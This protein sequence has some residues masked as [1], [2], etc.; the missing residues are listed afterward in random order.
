MNDCVLFKKT[1]LSLSELLALISA[2][3]VSHEGGVLSLDG[4]VILHNIETKIKI[5]LT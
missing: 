5:K 3:S 1:Y 4:D 2:G